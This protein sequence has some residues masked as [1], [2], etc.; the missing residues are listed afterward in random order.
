[1]RA[2]VT[3]AAGFAGYSLTMALLDKGYEVY[4]VLRPN[5]EHNKRFD[6]AIDNLRLIELDCSDF[7]C[8]P[9]HI[10]ESCDV[11]Y[12]LAWFGGRDDFVVQNN[13]INYNLKAVEAAS[14]LNCK[15]FIGIGS[16]AEYGVVEG[17][18]SE[19]LMPNPI[20]SYGSAKTAAMYLSK[21]RCQQLDIEWLWGRIFS[22]YGDYEPAGRMLP[23]L[24]HKLNLNKEVSL[25]SCEQYWDYL[26]V[27]DAAEAIVALGE[28]GHEGNIYN[29]AHGDY[30]PLKEYV[31]EAKMTLKS[32]SHIHY[33]QK[34][35]PFISLRPSVS[36]IQKDTGWMPKIDF[37]DGIKS[38]IESD[39]R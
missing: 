21:R 9:E 16:Q 3:G 33:G 34:A 14:K 15:R 22:L 36:K 8:I 12:H 5:S 35:R 24:L 2:V 27:K 6:C 25:S 17:L 7:D 32:E 28:K 29:I 30:R 10:E 20:N 19:D 38:F 23:D 1:M 13:N 18:I 39:N 4:A 37:R 11:F 26:H 31:E